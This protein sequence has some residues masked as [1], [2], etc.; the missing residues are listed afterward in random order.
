MAACTGPRLGNSR[1]I[2]LAAFAS[3]TTVG[4]E[5][6]EGGSAQQDKRR[7]QE[8]T[9]REKTRQ[10]DAEIRKRDER[11]KQPKT[12]RESQHETTTREDEL[13]RK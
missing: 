9:T 10:D 11:G 6:L 12:A 5:P 8:E 4:Y 2:N 3:P 1:S 7:V 13:T